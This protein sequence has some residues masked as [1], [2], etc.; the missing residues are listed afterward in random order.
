MILLHVHICMLGEHLHESVAVLFDVDC[1]QV[2][3]VYML[4]M[5]LG[6]GTRWFC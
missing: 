2:M 4:C 1:S 5:C 6:K 3:V